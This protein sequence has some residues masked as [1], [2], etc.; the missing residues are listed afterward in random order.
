MKENNHIIS[1][2]NIIWLIAFLSLSFLIL[3]ITPY[4][5]WSISGGGTPVLDHDKADL[6]KFFWILSA[7]INIVSAFLN[8]KRSRVFTIIFLLCVAFGIFNLVLYVF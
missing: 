1:I 3:L 8:L 2:L 7:L 4:Q 6:F 5:D